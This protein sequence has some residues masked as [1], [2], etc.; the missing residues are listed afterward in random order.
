[1]SI[2]L[3]GRVEGCTTANAL[4]GGNVDTVEAP[5]KQIGGQLGAT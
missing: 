5:G 2:K 1:M 3:Q 4:E